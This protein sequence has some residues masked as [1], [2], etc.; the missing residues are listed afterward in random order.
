M[1]KPLDIGAIKK[2]APQPEFI[3]RPFLK[4]L[5]PA[6]K[7]PKITKYAY[8]VQLVGNV[9]QTHS[10]LGSQWV[11][12]VKVLDVVNDTAVEANKEYTMNLPKV[13][14][15]KI[16]DEKTQTMNFKIGD[17][18]DIYNDG[19]VAGKSYFNF[20]VVKRDSAYSLPLTIL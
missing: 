14:Y 6:G 20:F 12:D 5:P 13:L 17:I 19:K 9:R 15:N 11:V 1:S 4:I 7:A 16:V 18:L 10:P 2:D 3:S 8:R